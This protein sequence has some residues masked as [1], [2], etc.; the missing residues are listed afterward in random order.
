MKNLAALKQEP[1]FANGDLTAKLKILL[2][3]FAKQLQEA[4]YPIEPYKGSFP[5]ER[6]LAMPE[7]RKQGLYDTFSLYYDTCAS[8]LQTG[9]RDDR[10]MA[11]SMLLPLQLTPLSD[12]FSHIQ[13]GDII[14]IYNEHSIQ[15]Y[16]SFT[17]FKL[18]SYTLEELFTY[19]WW[20]LYRRPQAIND[21]MFAL[22]GQLFTA[23]KHETIVE[24]V[25]SHVVEEIFS[26]RRKQAKITEVLLSPLIGRDNR[27]AG[28]IHVFRAE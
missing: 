9:Q 16:R 19:E 22:G 14:E 24:G 15:V 6:F 2:E 3:S 27:V 8:T 23:D 26:D 28:F 10:T 5:S 18:V 13:K 25:S 17:F 20:E 7:A 11:W 12:V 1:V 21:R 4:G